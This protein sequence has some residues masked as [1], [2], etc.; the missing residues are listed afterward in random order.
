VEIHSQS[1]IASAWD[2]SSIW[3]DQS[4]GRPRTVDDHYLE[5]LK[6]LAGCSP[7]E[8]GYPFLRWTAGWLKRHLAKETGLE[9]SERHINRLLKQMGLS[10]RQINDSAAKVGDRFKANRG[11]ITIGDLNP[12]SAHDL[13]EPHN[14]SN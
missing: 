11:R 6:E 4:S 3:S 10:T 1:S 9:V 13:A 5:R 12:P 8:Y 7:R 2:S 14:L